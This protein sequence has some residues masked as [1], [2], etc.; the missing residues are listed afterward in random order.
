MGSGRQPAAE[1]WAGESKVGSDWMSVRCLW[2][3]QAGH[4]F[5]SWVDGSGACERGG[6]QVSGSQ[7]QALL[8]GGET[9]CANTPVRSSRMMSVELRRLSVCVYCVCV[10]ES[11]RACFSEVGM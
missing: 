6:A 11:A 5:G 9:P 1:G 7:G 8:G 2:A 4:S 3:R 10:G